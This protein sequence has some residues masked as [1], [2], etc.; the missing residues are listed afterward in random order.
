MD[1]NKKNV[2]RN[3][4]KQK[5]EKLFSFAF[6]KLFSFVLSACFSTHNFTQEN[7][8]YYLL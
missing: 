5:K 7:Y 8:L 2:K 4:K 6:A 1:Y 3:L